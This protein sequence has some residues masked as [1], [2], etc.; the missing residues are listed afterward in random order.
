M[1]RRRMAEMVADAAWQRENDELFAGYTKYEVT[2]AP[3]LAGPAPK[4][5]MTYSELYPD[6]T[7]AF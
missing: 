3:A 5:K 4:R 6:N 7:D 1:E 2:E